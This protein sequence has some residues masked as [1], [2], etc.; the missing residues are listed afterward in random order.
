MRRALRC[1]SAA[2][3]F[4]FEGIETHLEDAEGA[5]DVRLSYTGITP[6]ASSPLSPGIMGPYSW[7]R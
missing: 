5:V 1:A 7:A 3:G 6:L 2:T 4:S